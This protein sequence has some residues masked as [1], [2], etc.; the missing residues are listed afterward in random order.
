M[1]AKLHLEKQ[2]SLKHGGDDKL[3]PQVKQANLSYRV[4]CVNRFDRT[5]ITCS[6]L[7]W[8]GDNRLKTCEMKDIDYWMDKI[9]DH[10]KLN[11]IKIELRATFKGKNKVINYDWEL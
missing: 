9:L 11:S 1:I 8:Q 2:R 10:C 3:L 4:Y 7:S 6:G 5:H